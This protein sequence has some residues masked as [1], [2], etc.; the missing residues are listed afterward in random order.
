MRGYELVGQE[1]SGYMDTLNNIA[2]NLKNL[3]R[4]NEA[5]I[6]YEKAFKLSEQRLGLENQDTLGSLKNYAMA[7]HNMGRKNDALFYFNRLVESLKKIGN[8]LSSISLFLLLLLQLLIAGDPLFQVMEKFVE[9][10]L[11]Q[12]DAELNSISGGDDII[13][14]STSMTNYDRIHLVKKYKEKG[15][16]LYKNALNQSDLFKKLL[17][18][19]LRYYNLSLDHL[20]KVIN[21]NDDVIKEVTNLKLTLYLNVAQCFLKLEAWNECIINCNLA[22]KIEE[23]NSKALYRR[24][25]C[26]EKIKKFDLALSDYLEAKKYASDSVIVLAEERVRKELSKEQSMKSKEQLI[27]TVEEYEQLVE[28]FCEVR[29]IDSTSKSVLLE[30]DRKLLREGDIKT[31]NES[32]RFLLSVVG[33]LKPTMSASE[34][35]SNEDMLANNLVESVIVRAREAEEQGLLEKAKEGTNYYYYYYYCLIMI[36]P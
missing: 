12:K 11:K 28:K 3:G 13:D 8:L 14:S 25:S 9:M 22:L 30:K 15:S 27:V 18:D 7:L 35:E 34:K 10:L 36:I 5:I 31:L 32:A 33:T 29:N 6:Y 20:T 1:H 21:E 17:P 24:G 16:S 19:A 2:I 4:M 26:Y 23:N